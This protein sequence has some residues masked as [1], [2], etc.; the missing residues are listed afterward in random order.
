MNKKK[1]WF[2]GR[3]A[4]VEIKPGELAFQELSDERSGKEWIKETYNF[5]DEEINSK[6]RGHI[7]KYEISF[8]QNESYDKV[9]KA[10]LSALLLQAIDKHNEVFG[11]CEVLIGNGK[12]VSEEYDNW[13]I[14]EDLGYWRPMSVA[15]CSSK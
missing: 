9:D 13:P 8:F 10:K 7:L 15:T 12:V 4:F 1:E 14:M 5:S 2:S 11:E 6:V 3:V